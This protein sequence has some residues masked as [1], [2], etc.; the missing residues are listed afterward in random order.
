[1]IFKNLL[2]L[3]IVIVVVITL[4]S[5][6]QN[7]NN[8]STSLSPSNTNLSITVS[9]T[10]S[11]KPAK[12][13]L[14]TD[15]SKGDA[16]NVAIEAYNEFLS[17]PT[18]EVNIFEENEKNGLSYKININAQDLN[19]KDMTT[20][21][22]VTGIDIDSYALFDINGDGI[23]E[24]IT[25]SS[26]V[27]IFSYQNGQVVSLYNSINLQDGEVSILS[28]GAIFTAHDTTGTEYDYVTFDKNATMTDIYFAQINLS[29]TEI[30]YYF[31]DANKQVSKTEWNKLTEKYFSASKNIAS[32]KKYTYQG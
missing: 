3:L 7:D 9:P 26:F 17:G 8:S 6:S 29:Q 19:I 30:G 24:L 25:Y 20:V 2:S 15:S 22:I 11:A 10:N 31:G 4:A 21:K 28:N 14:T 32:I 12:Q 5:C 27:N 16:Y 18:Q 13:Y 23:P 1:M